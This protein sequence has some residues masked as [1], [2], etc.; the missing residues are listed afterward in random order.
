[1]QHDVWVG[2][3][4]DDSAKVTQIMTRLLYG[5]DGASGKKKGEL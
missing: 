5:W 3:V 4:D 1:M 2:L